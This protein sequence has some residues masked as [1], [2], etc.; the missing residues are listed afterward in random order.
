[1]LPERVVV[2]RR[3]RVTASFLDAD[4][5]AITVGLTDG[6]VTITNHAGDTVLDAEPAEISAGV[7]SYE[8]PA[9]ELVA[10]DRLTAQWSA[11]HGGD[12]VR[13]T[14]AIEV[15]SGFLFE[16]PELRDDAEPLELT[17]STAQI[18]AAR[19]QAEQDLEDA[20]GRAFVTRFCTESFDPG[21]ARVLRLRQHH[22]HRIRSLSVDGEALGEDELANIAIRGSRDVVRAGGFR[23][24]IE[25]AYEA[26]MSTP[27]AGANR[28]ARK[29]A[30]HYLTPK[31]SNLH[32]RATS[33]TTGESTYSLV[34][35][36]VRNAGFAIPEVNAFVQREAIPDWGIS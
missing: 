17:L 11:T 22:V 18:A 21:T 31:P 27:P 30:L 29:L 34:T 13:M 28:A 33:M 23:G 16:I 26:G 4:G 14:T 19:I 1:M 15:V 3:S 25:I 9:D 10:L 6:T 7:I 20:C 24:P 32:E 12:E 8:I 35:P 36:G 5:E 2:G